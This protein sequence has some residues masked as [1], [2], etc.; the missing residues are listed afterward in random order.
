MR[1]SDCGSDVCASDLLGPGTTLLVDT[2][3]IRAGVETAVRV[4]GTGLGG[5]RIDSGDLPTVAADVRSQL[6]EL[7]ATGTRITVTSDLDEFAIAALAA[8]PVD[9]YG[10]GTSLVTGSGSPTPGSVFKL[11]ALRGSDGMAAGV[12][13]APHTN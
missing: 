1:I 8:S 12:A 3:D 6:D 2:Y 7:G 13:R 5:V 4:A 10:V 9:S 11:V